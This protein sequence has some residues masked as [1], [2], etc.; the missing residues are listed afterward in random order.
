MFQAILTTTGGLP[1]GGPLGGLA[2]VFRPTRMTIRRTTAPYGDRKSTHADSNA[3][4]RDDVQDGL[5]RFVH[6]FFGL[7]YVHVLS[8]N[9]IRHGHKV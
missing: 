4:R 2:L 6:L 1:F 8:R 9:Y 7:L 5:A 3:G